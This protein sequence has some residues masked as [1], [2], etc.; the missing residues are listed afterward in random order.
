M[1]TSADSL[2]QVLIQIFNIHVQ[3]N[4]PLLILAAGDAV[5]KPTRA[6]RKRMLCTCF[7]SDPMDAIFFPILTAPQSSLGI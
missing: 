6:C 1:Q 3:F 2:P 4:S 5:A 7:L